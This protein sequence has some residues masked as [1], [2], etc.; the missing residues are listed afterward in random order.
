VKYGP[1][2]ILPA[3]LILMGLAVILSPTG[4]IPRVPF[5]FREFRFGAGTFFVAIG[6]WLIYRLTKPKK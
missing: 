1:N 3:M 4:K 2:L 5:E 6:T